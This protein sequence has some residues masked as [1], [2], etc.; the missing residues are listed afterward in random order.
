MRKITKTP[1]PAGKRLGNPSDGPPSPPPEVMDAFAHE[2]KAEQEAMLR[3]WNYAGDLF[4]K[5]ENEPDFSAMGDEIWQNLESIIGSE[6]QRK[7]L[8]LIRPVTTRWISIAASIALLVAVGIGMWLRPVTVTVPYGQTASIT[9]PDG[10][11]VELNSGS[12][13]TYPRFFERSTREVHLEGEAF[14][15]VTSRHYPFIVKTFNASIQVLGTE[16]NVRAWRDEADAFTDVFL[17]SGSVKFSPI[18]SEARSVIL[19]PG[20]RSKVAS[21]TLIPTVPVDEESDHAL[22][23]REGRFVVSSESIGSIFNQIER[24][25]DVEITSSSPD[26]LEETYSVIYAKENSARG[27]LNDICEA[28]DCTVLAVTDGFKVSRNQ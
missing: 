2:S 20:Q 13:L 23:W 24:R 8:R 6:P 4:N 3:A 16:F 1:D 9:L 22:A 10:S 5:Q 18:Q 17:A 26:L 12:Q 19:K 11:T 14:F 15:D 25:F 7:P 28:K 27:I 21:T